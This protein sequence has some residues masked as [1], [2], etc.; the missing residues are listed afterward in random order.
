MIANT[1]PGGK[2]P[3]VWVTSMGGYRLYLNG[4]LLAWDNQPGRIRFIPLTVLPGRQALTVVGVHHGDA[5]GVLV[6]LDELDSSQVSSAAWK[7]SANP[8]GNAWK[9][10]SFSDTD[11]SAASASGTSSRRPDGKALTGWAASSGAKWIWSGNPADTAVVLRC[12]FKIAP[13]GFGQSTTGGAGGDTVVA[14]TPDRISAALTAAGAK[15]ILIPEGVYDLRNP[16][17]A[18]DGV[19][20]WCTRQ[21]GNGDLN[22]SNTYYR[23]TFDGTCGSGETKATSLMRW[24]R[25]IFVKP[26]K[27]LVGMGRGAVLRG[28]AM[29]IQGPT[30]GGNAVFRNLAIHDINPHVIE[31]GDGIT[32]DNASKLWID[33]CSFKWISDGNDMGGDS[34]KEHSITWSVYDGENHANCYKYD[35]YVALIEN[36]ELTYAYDYWVNTMGRVPKVVSDTR[37]SKVHIVNNYVNFNNYFLVGAHGTARFGAQVLWESSYMK[38]AKAYLCLKQNYGLIQSKNNVFSGTVGKFMYEDYDG[39]KTAA[40]IPE[41]KDNVFTPPY[42]YRNF[43]TDVLPTLIPQRAGIGAAWNDLPAYDVPAGL[44]PRGP[45][46]VSLVSGGPTS[47]DG[48]VFLTATAAAGDA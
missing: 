26:N 4:Q 12:S 17:S 24:D 22:S 27:T 47:T 14:S 20:D 40:A 43:G 5:P 28:S 21:C 10:P 9:L 7:A 35:P 15:V 41:P 13:V 36:A 1:Y 33:H 34:A 23:V 6:Q 37:E 8:V 18:I 46:K 32:S 39:G 3:G 31:G 38:D 19:W 29:Y 25:L 11:W 45:G 42:E 16:H 44:A 30:N 2:G 48:T